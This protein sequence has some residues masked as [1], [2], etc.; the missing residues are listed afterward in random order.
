[1]YLACLPKI[2]LIVKR[3]KKKIK[4]YSSKKKDKGKV[5]PLMCHDFSL[6][7]HNNIVSALSYI[8]CHRK[9]SYDMKKADS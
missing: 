1:M 7:R 3:G 4:L 5:D 9:L 6:V 8:I 2:S